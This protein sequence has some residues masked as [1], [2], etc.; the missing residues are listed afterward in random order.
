[1]KVMAIA[2]KD[3]GT[4]VNQDVFLRCDYR[5]LKRERLR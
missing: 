5:A 4:L 1:M 2:E 3:H